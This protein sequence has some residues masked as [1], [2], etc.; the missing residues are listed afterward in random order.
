MFDRKINQVSPFKKFQNLEELHHRTLHEYERCKTALVAEVREE[1][2][3]EEAQRVSESSSN[4]QTLSAE[5]HLKR[6][7]EDSNLGNSKRAKVSQGLGQLSG[8]ESSKSL[9]DIRYSR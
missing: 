5:Q 8:G 1:R 7:T 6:K 9:P 2:G 4:A 3:E